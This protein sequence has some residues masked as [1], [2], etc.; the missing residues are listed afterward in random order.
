MRSAL[1]PKHLLPRTREG[2]LRISLPIQR[3]PS[4]G[5]LRACAQS[6]ASSAPPTSSNCAQARS[7]IEKPPHSVPASVS[8]NSCLSWFTL[9]ISLHDFDGITRL[10][11]GAKAPPDS[12]RRFGIRFFKKHAPIHEAVAALPALAADRVSDGVDLAPL[13]LAER[14]DSRI[15]GATK[16]A[17]R[18][19]DRKLIESVV[20]RFKTGRSSVCISTQVGCAADCAFCATG[21]MGLLRNLTAAEIVGQVLEAGRLLRAESRR[22]RNLVFMG[23]GEPLHNERALHEAVE[24]LRDVRRCGFTDRHIVVSTVGVPD[25]MVRFARAFPGVK[26]ALSLH[27]ARQEVREAIMPLARRHSLAK[28]KAALGEVGEIQG[29]RVMIEY[30][31]LEGLTDRD[32]DLDAL[33]AYLEGIPVHIN[34]IPYNTVAAAGTIRGTSKEHREAFGARLKRAGFPVTL[35]YSLGADIDGACGQLVRRVTDEPSHRA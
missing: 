34:L 6:G 2:V 5:W 18:T 29:G 23:M 26:L 28:L 30:L 27:S 7:H 14:R 4:A 13:E 9:K 8:G 33:C 20:L 15:D 10:A 12:V 11:R 16:L 24:A 19:H 21:R 25:A 31:M 35:R 3:F 1:P 22:L 17:F 32:E